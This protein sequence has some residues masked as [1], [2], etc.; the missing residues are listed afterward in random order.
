MYFYKNAYNDCV[1]VFQYAT[2]QY[3]IVHEDE[4][5]QITCAVWR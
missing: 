3:V 2:V 4:G 5:K 1:D